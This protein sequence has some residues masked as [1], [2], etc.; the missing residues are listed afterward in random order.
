M[1]AWGRQIAAS[2]S[3]QQRSLHLRGGGMEFWAW[4]RGGFGEGKVM[5]G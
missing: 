1:A 4:C 5:E 2:G 3:Q